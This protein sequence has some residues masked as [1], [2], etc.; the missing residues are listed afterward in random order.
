[1][2]GL[3][4]PSACCSDLEK[5]DAYSYHRKHYC[6]TCKVIGKEFGHRSRLMLN[7]DTVFLAELLSMLGGEDLTHWENHL[8]SVNTC[9]SMPEHEVLP[10]SLR[11]A[12]IASVLLGELKVDDQI[13]DS[14]GWNWKL[15]RRFYSKAFEKA[16]NQLRDWGIDTTII[17]SMVAEQDLRESSK[18][19]PQRLEDCLDYYAEATAKI[20]GTIF[21][22]G[23]SVDLYNLGYEFGRLIYIL[24]AYQDY[25]KDVFKGNFN[26][27]AV[28]FG[29]Q[30]QLNESQLEE[31]RQLMMNTEKQIRSHLEELPLTAAQKELYESRLVS[32]LALQLYREREKPVTVKEIL[33]QRW[34]FAKDFANQVLCPSP[35]WWR[36]LN[37]YVLVFAVFV[38]PQTAEYLPA[39]GKME[40][41]KWGALI[42]AALASI[43]L[44]RVLRN[45]PKKESKKERK[46]FRRFKAFLEAVRNILFR[47]NTCLD[48]CCSSCCE[49]ACSGCCQR[50]CES[51]N[52]WF[53][54]L[55]LLAI[56]LTAGLVV[57]ILFLAG[58]I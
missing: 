55:I 35:G 4:R 12:A 46:R 56:I 49:S 14:K 16:A 36:Q 17:Y 1:M 48:S 10:F 53:W 38:S 21:Q 5:N 22:G 9:F 40:V 6:G 43:G 2:F 28:Y 54:I 26:P 57:L 24:D 7:F 13:K 39:E 25:E 37:Y 29:G 27:L 47:R 58:V 30:G 32:N 23:S 15:A 18:L 50:I 19:C 45:N 52:P 34:D 20:T 41:L 11:Y 8:Q 44:V 3:M 31:I 51:D 33:Q 42:T